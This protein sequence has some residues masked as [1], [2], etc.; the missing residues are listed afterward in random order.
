MAYT[1][2]R[3]NFASAPLVAFVALIAGAM[4]VKQPQIAVAGVLLVLL[5]AVRNESRTAGLTLLWIYWLLMPFIR[6]V[7]D[8]LSSAPGADPLSL[9]PFIATVLLAVMELRENRL[10]R[11]ARTVLMAGTVAILAGVPIGLTVDPAATM[12][13]AIAY[14]AGLSAF[15]LGWGDHVRP[16]SGSTLEQALR[17]ALVPMALYG[18]AQ[19]F[20][21]LTSWDDNWVTVSELAS[22]EAPQEGHVRVFSTLNSPFTFAITVA[23]GLMFGVAMRKR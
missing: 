2:S 11:R 21:P 22:I 19:Y 13:A 15:V 12:F 4:A 14:M 3:R 20:Y 10:S 9:L 5:F 1:L 17:V 8:L 18:I 7:I 16:R 6:R 23:V